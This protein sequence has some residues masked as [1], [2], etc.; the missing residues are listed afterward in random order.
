[1]L[2]SARDACRFTIVKIA[3]W[4]FIREAIESQVE[5]LVVGAPCGVMD[6]MAAVLGHKSSLMSLQCQP[7]EVPY[8]LWVELV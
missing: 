7:A 1:M 3:I 4:T 6:Q 8:S 2:Y 5:N